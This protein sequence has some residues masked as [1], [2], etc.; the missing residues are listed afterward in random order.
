MRRPT[1][2]D[3][4]QGCA[5]RLNR[6][7]ST[8]T[9]VSRTPELARPS[10]L[11]LSSM[12]RRTTRSGSGSPVPAAFE[13][14]SRRCSSLS[15]STSMAESARL[16][17]PV[18]MPYTRRLSATARST[19]ARAARTAS[20]ASGSRAM[21]DPG[22]DSRRVSVSASRPGRSTNVL[23][24]MSRIIP[25]RHLSVECH[26][27]P[28]PRPG[29]MRASSAGEPLHVAIPNARRIESTPGSLHAGRTVDLRDRGPLGTVT[30]N[31]PG[32]VCR[33]RTEV[34]SGCAS[35]APNRRSRIVLR[36][37]SGRRIPIPRRASRVDHRIGS[38]TPGHGASIGVC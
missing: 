8:S 1:P 11:I 23:S 38:R 27:H 22:S 33:R 29:R 10:V 34:K 6:L 4:M 15:R 13:R 7:I 12:V 19:T 16:P 36:T 17:I 28:S 31:R 3:G 18:L 37:A 2:L 32:D 24:F 21:R 9:I 20:R 26:H 35:R 14:I 30:L 5:S 25:F